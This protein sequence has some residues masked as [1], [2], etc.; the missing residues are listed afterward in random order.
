[1]KIVVFVSPA[2]TDGQ[3]RSI[4]IH[5][6]N[7]YKHRLI[8]PKVGVLDFVC[9]RRSWSYVPSFAMLKFDVGKDPD[10]GP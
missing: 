3:V 10:L 7:S 4:A 6:M 5:L 1:M 8:H 9:L 2:L